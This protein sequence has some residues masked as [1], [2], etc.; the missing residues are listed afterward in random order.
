M[1][2]KFSIVMNSAGN[3]NK[4]LRLGLRSV[5]M[6]WLTL[7]FL[8]LTDFGCSV[9]LFFL[10]CLFYVKCSAPGLLDV[11]RHVEFFVCGD[12]ESFVPHPFSALRTQPDTATDNSAWHSYWRLCQTRIAK[13]QPFDDLTATDSS[14]RTHGANTQPFNTLTVTDDCQTHR[15]KS[16]QWGYHRDTD[17]SA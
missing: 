2:V 1:M 4:S 7:C 6:L 5:G 9:F 15:A 3:S 14:A 13:T 12:T 17:L 10:P 8:C 11:L 16:M